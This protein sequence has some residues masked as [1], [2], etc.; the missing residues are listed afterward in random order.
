MKPEHHVMLEKLSA[1][2][3]IDFL[4]ANKSKWAAYL[5]FVFLG[6]LGLHRFY[7]NEPV[8]GVCYIILFVLSFAISPLLIGLLIWFIIDLFWINSY[9]NDRRYSKLSQ[10]QRDDN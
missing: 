9:I 5:L 7:L 10:L 8:G 4:T 6:G 2:K 3:K 1:D